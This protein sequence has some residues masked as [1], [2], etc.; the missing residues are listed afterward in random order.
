MQKEI[1]ESGLK[2]NK[3]KMLRDDFLESHQGGDPN[4]GDGPKYPCI[5][6]SMERYFQPRNTFPNSLAL[7]GRF[8][9]H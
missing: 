3:K 5:V 2:K 7:L 6:N 1:Q 4:C 9:C 8:H